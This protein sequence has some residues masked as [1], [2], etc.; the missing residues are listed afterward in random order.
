MNVSKILDSYYGVPVNQWT[1]LSDIITVISLDQEANIYTDP[2]E[3]Y[4]FN[5]S[6]NILSISKNYKYHLLTKIEAQGSYK[7][8]IYIDMNKISGFISTSVIGPYGTIMER[9]Y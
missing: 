5:T 1:R 4:Y 9:P 2:D 3:L 6:T 8:Y 7:P